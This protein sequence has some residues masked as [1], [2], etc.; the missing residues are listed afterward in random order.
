MKFFANRE[1]LRDIKPFDSPVFMNPTCMDIEISVRN[2]RRLNSRF[3]RKRHGFAI[4]SLV[5]AVSGELLSE[6]M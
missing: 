1:I 5:R 2:R 6:C 3:T 4:F